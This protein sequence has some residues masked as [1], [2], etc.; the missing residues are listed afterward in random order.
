MMQ[1]LFP[2]DSNSAK[3]RRPLGGATATVY[4]GNDGKRE[5]SRASPEHI[6]FFVD[7]VRVLLKVHYRKSLKWSMRL[8]SHDFSSSVVWGLSISQ[9]ARSRSAS[10]FVAARAVS[11]ARVYA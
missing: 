1:E 10:R 7:F 6:K 3:Q 8:P 11:P 5:A 4:E 9:R 2:A